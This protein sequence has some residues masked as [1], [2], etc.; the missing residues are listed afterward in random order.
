MPAASTGTHD[1]PAAL[2]RTL[3]GHITFWSPEMEQRYGFAAQDA[4]GQVSHKLLKTGSWQSHDEIQAVLLQ[5]QSWNGGLILHR[6]DGRPMISANHWHLHPNTG[7]AGVLVTEIHCNIVQAGSPAGREL[8]DV[9][10]TVA[11]ELSQP[12]TAVVSYLSVAR[13]AIKPARPDNTGAGPA[14]T[15]ANAQLVRVREILDRMRAISETLTD[16]R[17]HRLNENLTATLQQTERAVCETRQIALR[18][19]PPSGQNKHAP[20]VEP[21]SDRTLDQAAARAISLQNIQVLRRFL[22]AERDSRANPRT[23]Q[24]LMRLLTDEEARLATDDPIGATTH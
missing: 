24:M 19:N 21:M 11:H 6:A 14:I 5:K 20:E 13:A 15:N 7:G 8:A 16:S 22:F 1:P 9:V 17:L 18:T 2:I 12:L 3:E 4:L 23:R 10:T